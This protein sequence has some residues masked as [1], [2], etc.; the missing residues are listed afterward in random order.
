MPIT[1]Q[2]YTYTAEGSV[3][4]MVNIITNIDPESNYLLGKINEG[5][6]AT[7]LT[8]NWLSDALRPPQ[9]NKHLE[10]VDFTSVEA[11]ARKRH[12]NNCQHFMNSVF[13][14][15]AQEKRKKYV[16][17][18][19]IGYQSDKMFLEHSADIEYAIMKSAQTSLGD[20]STPGAMGGIQYFLDRCKLTVTAATD[21][22]I[23]T[24]GSD[25]K[26][27]T[28]EFVTFYSTGTLPTGLIAD[29]MYYV[30]VLS[31][32]T[33][34]V[35][36]TLEDAIRNTNVVNITAAGSGTHYVCLDN[37]I[38][39]GG[40]AYTEDDIN[41]AMQYAWYRG[42]KPTEAILSG[43]NKRRFSGFTAGS[44]KTRSQKEKE[45]SEVVNTYNSDFG[46]LDLTAHRLQSNTRIDIF[47]WQYWELRWFDRTHEIEP[48][49]KGTYEERVIES[50]LTLVNRAPLANAACIN[51]KPTKG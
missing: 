34:T 9:D 8:V 15:D 31:A 48:A 20:G 29:E 32:T 36:P 3:E 22:E 51:I 25:H 26:Y 17:D 2:S 42:G 46:N 19:E 21:T 50:W 44:Q 18:S 37:I 1:S 49:K 33:F 11:A 23:L 14:T 13:V 12:T 38:D 4:D 30:H 41:Q 6:P 7:D 10:K 16:V 43:R 24:T 5:E 27:Q 35:H 45:L 47:D 28:G 39:C 40:A